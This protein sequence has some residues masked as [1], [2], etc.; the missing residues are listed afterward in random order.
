MS[1][2]ETYDG[3]AWRLISTLCGESATRNLA[4][5]SMRIQDLYAPHHNVKKIWIVLYKKDENF[6]FIFVK[7]DPAF[8]KGETWGLYWPDLE[9]L[10]FFLYIL[11]RM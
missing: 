10:F 9:V 2:V 3:P 5:H 7:I 1:R 6:G 8:I 11:P 4:N